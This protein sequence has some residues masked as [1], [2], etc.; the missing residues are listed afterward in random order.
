MFQKGS[1][2]AK[3][4]TFQVSAEASKP[5]VGVMSRPIGVATPVLE[6]RVVEGDRLDEL[7]RHYYNDSR[8]WWRI[9]D[10][11]PQFLYGHDALR[12]EAI[13]REAMG[14]T[15]LDAMVGQILLIPKAKE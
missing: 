3:S 4:P 1:R 15:P 13:D 9:V 12:H 7:A 6:H 11:N 2:Y 8:L 10:A 5:F 14:L